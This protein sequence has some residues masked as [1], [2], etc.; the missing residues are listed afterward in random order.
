M[1]IYKL[2]KSKRLLYVF[3][4]RY[5]QHN[6][7]KPIV[8]DYRRRRLI[9]FDK[10]L[11]EFFDISNSITKENIKIVYEYYCEINSHVDNLNSAI[12]DLKN[13]EE[14]HVIKNIISNFPSV[15]EK[16]IYNLVEVVVSIESLINNCN[17]H[18]EKLSEKTLISD[19]D[20]NNI[21]EIIRQKLLN[22]G[23]SEKYIN[24]FMLYIKT[25]N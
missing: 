13:S 14:R 20:R 10:H 9:S 4:Q 3:S 8:F 25:K 18:L 2:R 11:V 7:E 21:D 16:Y 5:S 6:F 1:D 22:S 24:P 19:E 15:I 12:E 23:V 17:N